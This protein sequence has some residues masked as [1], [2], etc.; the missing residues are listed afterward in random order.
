[1]LADCVHPDVHQVFGRDAEADRVGD[2]RRARLELPGD[3]V[4]LAAAEVDLADH[5][6]AGEE[7]R[8][9]VEQLAAPHSAPEPIGASILWPLKA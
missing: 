9:R 7:R 8:H 6:A 5:L 4:E 1:M 2:R 3:L